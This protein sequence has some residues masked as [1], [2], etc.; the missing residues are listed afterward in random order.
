MGQVPDGLARTVPE[1]VLGCHRQGGLRSGA[2]RLQ[3]RGG[4]LRGVKL[5]RRGAAAEGPRTEAWRRP[6]VRCRARPPLGRDA[7]GHVRLVDDGHLEEHEVGHALLGGQGL[8][9]P[10][11]H[12]YHAQ[13]LA[14][15]R[16]V[17]LPQRPRV[18][19]AP[20]RLCV[21]EGV[22][23]LERRGERLPAAEAWHGA[24]PRGDAR[25]VLQEGEL[26]EEHLVAG[27][28]R[29]R[30]LRLLRCRRGRGPCAKGP[31]LRRGADAHPPAGTAKGHGER[32]LQGAARLRRG[33][34]GE[35]LHLREEVGGLGRDRARARAVLGEEREAARDGELRRGGALAE[36]ARLH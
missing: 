36:E 17:R 6:A 15:R 28:V 31:V 12:A 18:P 33:T 35:L 9:V 1:V 34:H 27:R 30:R 16:R 13:A 29:G 11:V 25:E 14:G 4:G 20:A 8:R 5:G 19:D 23:V 24:E 26:P 21:Q 7:G 32:A 22:Q 2:A 10:R 3:G